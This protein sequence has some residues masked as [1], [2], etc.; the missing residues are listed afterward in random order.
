MLFR[1]SGP[2]AVKSTETV[3]AVALA[4][5]YSVST[6]ASASYTI[7][8][9][10]A[11]P[12][13][14]LAGGSYASAQTVTITD[15]TTGATI[16]YT[17]NGSTPTTSSTLYTGAIAVSATETLNAV[18]M[19]TGYATS[20]IASVTYTINNSSQAA[21]P[22]FNIPGG[23]YNTPQ[24][25]TISDSTPGATIYYLIYAC[26]NEIVQSGSVSSG[27]GIYF[28]QYSGQ[29]EN[30]SISWSM[31]ATAPGYLQSSTVDSYF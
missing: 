10:T 25:V 9:T 23:I 8:P 27:G 24:T 28:E 4:P 15:T 31:Y 26:G 7:A 17:T 3:K 2:I 30:C 11:T 20:A 13:F 6:V 29:Y 14:S 1:S 5:H 22:V 18:A 21:A 16:Y 19:A 12:V